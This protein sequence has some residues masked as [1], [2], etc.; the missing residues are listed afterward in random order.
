VLA[1]EPLYVRPKDLSPSISENCKIEGLQTLAIL[2][3]RHRGQL[4]ALMNVASRLLGELPVSVRNQLEAIAAS[5]GGAVA[6]LHAEVDLRSGEKMLRA[7]LNATTESAFMLDLEGRILISNAIFAQRLGRTVEELVGRRADEFIPPDRMK[8]RWAH[9]EVAVRSG[10]P[11]S[12]V[13]E[14]AG[15][16]YRNRIYP[17]LDETGYVVQ[18]AVFSADVTEQKQAE[19]KVRAEQQL[20][21][22]LLDLRER[23]RKLIS[24]EMHDGFLQDIVAA[25]MVLAGACERQETA[26]GAASPDLGVAREMIEKG[27][28]EARR[29]I[30]D[31]RPMTIDQSGIVEAVTDIVAG[32]QRDGT[33]KIDFQHEGRFDRLDEMLEGAIFRIVHEAINNA[34]RHSQT[35][36]LSI[37][38]VQGEGL[39][40][41]IED[42]GVGFDLEQVPK[43]RFGVRGIIERARL[44]GGQA[45]IDT[46]PGKGTRITVILPLIE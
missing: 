10:E 20:L 41:R 13:D 32:E 6:R 42:Q 21:R 26:D 19:R 37:R 33:L 14:R 23:E 28:T 7:L 25:H 39:M 36:S 34:K 16:H 27:I 24:H 22:E 9:A 45:T 38:L 12:F 17:V 44:F 40:L 5:V 46:E 15:R 4:V 11:V 18:L 43:D 29:M 30:R 31:L 35:D 8:S 2:P 3:I 1:G